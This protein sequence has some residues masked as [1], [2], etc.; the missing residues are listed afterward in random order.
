MPRENNGTVIKGKDELWYGRVRWTDETNNKPRDKK[1]PPQKSE[2]AAWKLVHGFKKKL[3]TIGTKSV[4]NEKMTFGQFAD[5][6][7]KVYLVEPEFQDGKKIKGVVL[8]GVKAKMRAFRQFFGN[9]KLRS[10]KYSDIENF[11]TLRLKTPVTQTGKPRK[12]ATVHRELSLLRRIF[13]LAKRDELIQTNP[14]EGGGLVSTKAENSRDRVLSRAEELRLFAACGERTI[15]YKRYG[16]KI[17]AQ[18]D[19]EIRKH[20][21]PFLVCA[22]D[23]AM[24]AGEISKLEWRDIDLEKQAN[25]WLDSEQK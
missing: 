17:T 21:K 7:E 25:L 12:I 2:S 15:I 11:K 3:E 6:F 5:K 4:D 24:R 22:L 14:F 9:K 18:D 20:L 1:F 13:T 23:T 8:R 10:V 19:G 16:K